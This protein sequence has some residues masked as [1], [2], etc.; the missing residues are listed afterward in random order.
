MNKMLNN[1]IIINFHIWQ[2]THYE[3]AFIKNLII[4]K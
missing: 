4:K 2:I 3:A 1:L